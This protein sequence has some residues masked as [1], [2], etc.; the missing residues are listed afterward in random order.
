MFKRSV[1]MLVPVYRSCQSASSILTFPSFQQ[2]RV[3]DD[4]LQLHVDA[5]RGHSSRRT[6]PHP[7]RPQSQ[8]ILPKHRS[9]PPPSALLGRKKI[10]PSVPPF[11][12]YLPAPLL[13]SSSSS[14]S[15][16]YSSSLHLS[17]PKLK[18]KRRNTHKL[19]IPVINHQLITQKS[20]NSG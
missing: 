8:F 17:A 1:I 16:F 5:V 15:S 7:R 4:V 13:S 10:Q 14:F 2:H 20:V 18:P 9:P 12:R 11:V 6:P 19:Y 3:G